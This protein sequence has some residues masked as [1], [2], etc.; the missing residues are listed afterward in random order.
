MNQEIIVLALRLLMPLAAI[1]AGVLAYISAREIKGEPGS[2]VQ[3]ND[4]RNRIPRPLRRSDR[5]DELRIPTLLVPGRSMVNGTRTVA[6]LLLGV[7]THRD[8]KHKPFHK[9]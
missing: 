2:K 1:G 5:A 4:G 9:R 6:P 7:H 3:D 8:G